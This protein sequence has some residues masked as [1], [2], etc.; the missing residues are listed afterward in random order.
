MAKIVLKKTPWHSWCAIG[1]AKG[2]QLC[3]KGRKLVLFITGLC[4]QRCFY[5]PV[6]ELKSGKDVVYANEWK[7][8]NPDD[9][10]ELIE[11]AE[12]TEAKGAGITGGDPLVKTER[13]VSYI[14]LLKKKFGRNFHIHLYTPFKLVTEEKLKLLYDAG[15]DEIRFHPDLDDESLWNRLELARKYG[16]DIGV[17]IPVIP[18]YEEKT[19]KLI[20]FLAGK[21]KFL[22]LNELELSDTQ[23]E[24]Y[25]LDVMGFKPKDEISYGASGSEELGLRLA[26]YSADKGI[27]THFCTAKLK[28]SVQMVQRIRRRA[29]NTALPFD[30]QTKE[31]TLV[32]GCAYLKEL[33][34]GVGYQRSIEAAD[35]TATINRLNSARLQVI[36]TLNEKSE[37]VV[38]DENRLRLILPQEKI[39]GYAQKLKKLGLVPAV[40]E[41]YPT[42]DALEVEVE[43]L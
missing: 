30:F 28:D 31:G 20:D 27:M 29:R 15:L 3:V 37:N 38:V 1:M 35:K 22:N 16:W 17:E 19:M 10:K 32:R 11:E 25:K 12:L 39:R 9:P 18:G 24:Q 7:V 5:C 43:L 26:K 13:C 8:S 14:R 21:I 40:V 42:A 34:P 36:S 2:C 6:S 4:G 33:A 23:I 41:E